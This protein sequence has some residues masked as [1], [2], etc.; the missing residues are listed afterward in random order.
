M[1]KFESP[2]RKVFLTVNAI[3]L[4]LIGFCCFAPMWHV[5]CCSVSDPTVLMREQGFLLWPKGVMDF[6]GYRVILNYG[7]I[8]TGY[9][10]TLIYVGA[11][12][13]LNLS[14]T[15]VAAYVLSRKR[16]MPRN[17]LMLFLSF[18]MLFNGGLIPNYLLILKLGLHNSRWALILPNAF[19]VFNLVIMRTTFM[20]IPEAL[21][22]SARLEGASE[23]QVMLRIVVPVSK[24]TMA[25]IALF[26]SVFIWNSW[27][28]ASIYLSDRS[29]W[30]L[31]MFLQEILISNSQ[32]SIESGVKASVI[33]QQ[34]LI[35]YCTIVVATLPILCLYPF[36]QKYFVKGMMIGSI[37]G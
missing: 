19:S 34:T 6:S 26:V 4:I 23:L 11:G 16:F 31:Q 9:K 13:L 24:A 33:S 15:T 1:Q 36:L 8:W 22:E 5:V 3:F 21:D 20:E 29:K 2:G 14:L 32:R 10:N 12:V 18:T 25:V 7:N 27:F 17:G 37:K 35:K 30:P 28:Q